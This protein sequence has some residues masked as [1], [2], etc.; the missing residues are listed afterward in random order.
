V[1][2]GQGTSTIS[3]AD[4]FTY[5]TVSTAPVVTTLTPTS[6]PAAG[7]TAVTITGSNFTGATSV[8]FGGKMATFHIVSD[9]EITTTSPSHAVGSVSVVVHSPAGH[10]S[11][12]HKFTYV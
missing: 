4:H 10:S 3:A 6:G 9:T 2:T 1:T 11:K 5:G 7:G 12:T 8:T